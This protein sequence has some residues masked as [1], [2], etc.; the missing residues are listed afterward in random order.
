MSHPNNLKTIHP[1]ALTKDVKPLVSEE[2]GR[3]IIGMLRSDIS[4]AEV[5][6]KALD[7]IKEMFNNSS[8]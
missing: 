1:D 2:F 5:W 4:G 3:L 7:E 6:R 8:S